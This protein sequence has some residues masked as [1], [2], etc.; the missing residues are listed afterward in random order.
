MINYSVVEFIEDH[1][2]EAV[3]TNWLK[4]NIC[5][6]PKTKNPSNIRKLIERRSDPNDTEFTFFKVAV[7]KTTGKQN[8]FKLY[9]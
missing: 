2:I 9:F 7:L 4:K 1:A 3:P 6:W 5:A 8:L